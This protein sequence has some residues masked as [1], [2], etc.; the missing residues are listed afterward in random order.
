MARRTIINKS[1]R[2]NAMPVLNSMRIVVC[3]LV[4]C[5]AVAGELGNRDSVMTATLAYC[6]YYIK[7]EIQNRVACKRKG[8]LIMQYASNT[9]MQFQ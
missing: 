1:A 6:G 8:N 3:L 4:E 2:L 9:Q 5:G 7:D